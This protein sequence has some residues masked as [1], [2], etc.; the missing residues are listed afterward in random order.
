MLQLLSQAGPE[1]VGQGPVPGREDGGAVPQQADLPRP[2]LP[3]PG[4]GPGPG[5]RPH[6]RGGAPRP[7]PHGQPGAP[8]G[9]AQGGQARL[10]SRR[11][12]EPRESGMLFS[13]VA[14]FKIC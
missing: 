1:Q 13:V 14:K 12:V 2:P 3:P 8:R 6:R 9:E 10:R 7:R 11:G 5:G 4:L